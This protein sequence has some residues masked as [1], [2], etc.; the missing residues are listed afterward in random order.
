MVHMRAVPGS[1]TA[2]HR[3]IDHRKY[4]SEEGLRGGVDGGDHGPHAGTFAGA[5]RYPEGRG[6]AAESVPPPPPR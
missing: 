3:G 2:P 5:G 1:L 4:D 6:H